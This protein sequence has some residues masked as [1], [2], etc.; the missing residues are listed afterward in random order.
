VLA[1]PSLRR[2][3][4]ATIET[5]Q[6]IGN[7]K[8][9]PPGPKLGL[10]RVLFNRGGPAEQLKILP[11]AARDYGPVVGFRFRNRIAV[12]LLDDPTQIRYVLRTNNRNYLKAE[13]YELVKLVLGEG[14]LASEGDFWRRQ[15]R[16][17]QPAFHRR[18][19]AGLASMMVAETERT[20]S[21]RSDSSWRRGEPFDVS[22]EMTD[23]T[24]R[25]VS[26]AL[27]GP[28]ADRDFERISDAQAVL[29]RYLDRMTAT[30]FSLPHWVPTPANLRYRRA[31][32]TLHGVMDGAIDERERGGQ[33]GDDLLSML[34]EARDERTGEGMDKR[35][36]RDEAM[37]LLFAGH[38]TTA[39][40]LSWTWWLLGTHPEAESRLHEEL[41]G[42]LA[43][44]VPEFEDLPDL[45]Y[46][47]M[48]FQEA[49]RLY[50]PAWII[51]RQSIEDD[52]VGGYRIP[53]GTTVLISS[54]VTHRN[55]RY[56][57][58][59]EIFDPERFLPERSAGRPEFAYLPFGGGPRKCIGDHFAMTEGVLI[60]A[61]IAQRYRLL[62]VPAHPVEPQPLLTLKPKRGI[63]VSLEERGTHGDDRDLRGEG[64]HRHC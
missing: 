54:Y 42:V 28:A 6:R 21:R 46:T 16:L 35:Q 23:L 53:A 25:I 39:A 29:G 10:D 15:R 63:I 59:P 4:E 55:P 24:L 27:F 57:E 41:D 31:L 61:T 7:E 1:A 18:R 11:A 47:R 5:A 52:E 43:G 44:R 2:S 9:S 12:V 36:L 62:P 50:P 37:T 49:T 26:K 64:R 45:S 17:V 51:S 30:F 38:E 32:A 22:Q 33:R 60:L 56:W 13:Q 40:A 8:P 19:I 14:L 34:L 3:E 20:L 58:D 48:V